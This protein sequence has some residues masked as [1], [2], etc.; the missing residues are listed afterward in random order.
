M[1]AWQIAL[2]VTTLVLALTALG[3]SLGVYRNHRRLAQSAAVA[4]EKQTRNEPA[5]QLVAFI[6]N[7]T[8]PDVAELQTAVQRACATLGMPT[9]LWFETT[10]EDPGIGQTRDALDQGAEVV[11]ALGG[12]G[13]VRAVAEA[14]T[15]TGVPMALLPLGTG[16][17]LARNLDIPIG[18][19]ED[20]LLI[21]LEGRDRA[22][23]VGW[24]EVLEADPSAAPDPDDA[25]APDGRALVGSK[26]IFLVIAGLGFDAAMV[27]DTDSKLKA[28][29]GW[30]A[31]FL[32]GIR[33]LHGRR[34]E[35]QLSL[36]DH[37]PVRVKVRT[38]MMGNCG[39]LPGGLTLMPDAVVDDG[40]LDIAALDTRGGIAGWAQLFGEVVMQGF[41]VSNDLPNKIG[42]IDHTQ[43]QSITVRVREGEQAQVDGDIIGRAR[44]I[45]SWVDPGALT[46]RVPRRIRLDRARSLGVTST[47]DPDGDDSSRG[48]NEA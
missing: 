32:S 42:R 26:H 7:P 46:V 3:I 47:D 10:A 16:N 39:K 22:I 25:D 29:V 4:P 18:N 37:S 48:A 17:L 1:T 38:V 40:L 31:Y 34:I 19:L 23:D 36:D 20:A 6:A 30:I 44:A 28:R 15:G 2:T 35:M 12:D 11:V 13:T 45:R 43:C 33:H 21:A 8:K 5:G 41:G 24:V 27:A 9:P 14:I